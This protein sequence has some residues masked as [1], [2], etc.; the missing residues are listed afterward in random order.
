MVKAL[1]SRYAARHEIRD[2][3][4]APCRKEPQGLGRQDRF[5]GATL[6]QFKVE[7][8]VVVAFLLLVVLGPLLLFTP[9]LPRSARDQTLV[10]SDEDPIG[11]GCSER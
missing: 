3:R 11:C 10:S 6:L 4:D 7:I 5:E 8:I 9:H 1:R 2:Q